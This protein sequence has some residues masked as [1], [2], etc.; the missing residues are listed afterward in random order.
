MQTEDKQFPIPSLSLSYRTHPGGA[1]ATWMSPRRQRSIVWSGRYRPI[2]LYLGCAEVGWQLRNSRITRLH[3]NC[4]A[5]L[6]RRGGGDTDDKHVPENSLRMQCF[7][8]NNKKNQHFVLFWCVC[9]LSSLYVRH[10][11]RAE[12]GT[13]VEPLWKGQECIRQVGKFGPFSIPILYISCL[14]Y[15]SWQATSFERPPSW[16]A[17]IEGFQCILMAEWKSAVAPVRQQWSY[18]SLVL[19]HRYM[20]IQLPGEESRGHG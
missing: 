6:P 10:G 18:C 20:V 1:W 8:R 11:Y 4:A 2:S 15:S 7:P 12:S 5:K 17:F 16:V 9:L 13:T 3:R 14:F 19:S